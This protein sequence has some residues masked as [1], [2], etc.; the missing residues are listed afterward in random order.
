MLTAQLHPLEAK[1]NGLQCQLDAN[2]RTSDEA[3]ATE[4]R[5]ADARARQVQLRHEETTA[6]QALAVDEMGKHITSLTDKTNK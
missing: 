2:R 5:E 6:K 3:L 1:I 4:R